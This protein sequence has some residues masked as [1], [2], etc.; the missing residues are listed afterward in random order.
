MRP[1]LQ[2]RA[3][4]AEAEH[5]IHHKRLP[6]ALDV[7]APQGLEFEIALGQFVGRFADED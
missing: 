2:P 7:G 4:C 5:L 6:Q 1:H 3:Q